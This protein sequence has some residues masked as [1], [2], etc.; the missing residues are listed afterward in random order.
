MIKLERGSQP[1]HLT[2]EKIKELVNIFKANGTAVWN[3]DKIKEA[4]S[5]SSHYKC[6]YCECSISEESKYMEVEHFEHKD[7]YKDKV[8]SWSN[9]LP[10]CKRCNIAKGTHDTREVPIVNPFDQDPKNH[11][12]FRLYRFKGIDELGSDTIE[13]IDLNNYDRVV[14]KRFEVGEQIQSSLDVAE[15]RYESYLDSKTTR[16]RN[17][18]INVIETMLR[19][20]QPSA[21]YSATSATVLFSDTKFHKIKAKMEEIGLWQEHLETL[22]QN[23]L[24]LALRLDKPE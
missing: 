11:L 2:D 21:I 6:A 13:A 10:A 23:A 9:L 18:L 17:R 14:S 22:Y 1:E 15:E 5:K 4:L 8:V 3:D 16:R 12:Y 7:K 20:C 24:P 19:E